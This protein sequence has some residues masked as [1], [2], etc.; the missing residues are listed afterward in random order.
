MKK[1]DRRGFTLLLAALV[2]TIVLSLGAAIY[3]IAFKQVVLS[4]IGRDSQLAFY[5]ADTMAECALYWDVRQNIFSTSS[6]ATFPM[7][8]F[9]MCLGEDVIINRVNN[10][11]SQSGGSWSRNTPGNYTFTPGV[12]SPI[13]YGTITVQVSGAG[14]GGGGGARVGFPPAG[15]TGGTGSVTSFD[16]TVTANSGT[17]GVGG[18]VSGSPAT[19]GSG[20]GGSAAGGDT[21]TQGGGQVGGSGGAG[22]GVTSITNVIFITSGTSWTVPSD[23]NNSNNSIEVVGGGGGGSN[24]TVSSTRGAG[25]GGGGYTRR[26]NVAMPAG[27][28]VT[29]AVGSGGAGAASADSGGNNGGDTYICNALD[30]GANCNAITASAVVVGAKGGTGAPASGGAGTGGA[31]ASGVPASGATRFSGGNGGASSNANSGAGGGGAAGPSGNGAAG[32]AT[33]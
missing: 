32:G 30:T 2:A 19:A 7:T 8:V 23:W 27:T 17:G 21:N 14:G 24:S 4:S 25:G 31:A 6:S 28:A 29:I 11:I 1:H 26:D 22:T 15:G 12:D 16:G 10:E 5:A 13:N 20:T 18:F 9:N 33:I 3:T